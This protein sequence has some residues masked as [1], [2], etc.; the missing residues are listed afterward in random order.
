MSRIIVFDTPISFFFFF[1]NVIF[2]LGFFRR[3]ST[4]V[5]PNRPSVEILDAVTLHYYCPGGRL[6]ILRIKTSRFGLVRLAAKT[7]VDQTS[8]SDVAGGNSFE[9]AKFVA[10]SSGVAQFFPRLRRQ[11]LDDLAKKNGLR[12]TACR[13]S[14]AL[15]V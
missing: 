1:F 12:R 8:K 11:T 5:L 9:R 15:H 10:T 6:I 2:P 13:L 4:A 3:T 14:I 7:A